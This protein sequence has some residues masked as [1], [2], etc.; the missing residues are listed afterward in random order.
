MTVLYDEASG[1]SI[2]ILLVSFVFGNISIH[3]THTGF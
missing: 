3:I 1:S 2:K